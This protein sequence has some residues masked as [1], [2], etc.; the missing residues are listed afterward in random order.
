MFNG[1]NAH[2][3]LHQRGRQG[4]IAHVGCKGRYLDSGV[5]IDP[6]KDN[7]GIDRCRTQGEVDF[8]TGVQSHSGRFDDVF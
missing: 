2:I 4:G 7:A 3:S 6:G 8:L 5:E 1:G